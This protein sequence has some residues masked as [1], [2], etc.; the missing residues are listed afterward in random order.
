M[1]VSYPS[2]LFFH[3]F[4]HQ[5]EELFHHEHCSYSPAIPSERDFFISSNSINT[6]T[7]R[8]WF[9]TVYSFPHFSISFDTHAAMIV[10]ARS[11][12]RRL[13]PSLKYLHNSFCKDHFFL[14]TMHSNNTSLYLCCCVSLKEELLEF[15][16]CERWYLRCRLPPNTH[17]NILHLINVCSMMITTT[18]CYHLHLYLRRFTTA[19]RKME[20]P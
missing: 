14:S 13:L 3:L 17:V 6:S 5:E 12:A 20:T 10:V 15:L 1:A 19:T 7:A 18:W 16:N 11:S 4:L 9:C 2:T 8:S